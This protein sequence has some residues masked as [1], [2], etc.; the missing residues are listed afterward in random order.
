M[1]K[2]LNYIKYFF[3]IFLWTVFCSYWFAADWNLSWINII[4]RQ[5]WWA[6]ETIRFIPWNPTSSWIQASKEAYL[7]ELKEADFNAYLDQRRTEY[8]TE[9]A[10]NYLISN[11]PDEATVDSYNQY[12]S[13]NR[14]KWTESVKNKKTKLIVHHTAENSSWILTTWDAIKKIQ[15]I[16]KYHTLNRWWWDIWYNFLID[17]LWNIYE[18]RAGGEWVIWAHAKR[19]NS[20]SVWISVLWNF[21]EQKVSTWILNSLTKLLTSL[22]KK[23]N[24]NPNSKVMYHEDKII[25]K[26]DPDPF[27]YIQDAEWY[28]IWWHK[29]WWNTACPWDNLYKLLP[30]IRQQVAK[31]INTYTLTNLDKLVS[32]WSS[33][34]QISDKLIS[35]FTSKWEIKSELTYTWA[36]QLRDQMQKSIQKMKEKYAIKL[37]KGSPT[38]KINYKIW[39]DEARKLLDW[40]ISVLLYELT[41]NFT[42]YQIWCLWTC[43]FD[44]DWNVYLSPLWN[45]SIV[46][47][48]L[49]L[50]IWSNIYTWSSLKITSSKDLVMFKNYKRKSYYSKPRNAFRGI[51][52]IKKQDV[53]TIK[54]KQSNKFAVINTL[55][56]NDYMKW[57]V[58]TNDWESV[59]KNKVMSMISKSY[60]LFYLKNHHPNIPLW[61]D[62]TAVDSPDIFQKYVWA[63]AEITL[64]KRPKAIVAT[65][66]LLIT[67]DW[68]VPILPYFNCSP[69]FTYSAKEKRW[70][71]DT[72]YLI[73][74]IDAAK[75]S[76]FAWHWV[77]MSGKWAEYR[78]KKWWTY[79]QIL[80]YYYPWINIETIQR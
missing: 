69:W 24:I 8:Q 23:Y 43:H 6:N 76:D 52:S 32:K 63:W 28:A 38:T 3:P 64:Q 53:K 78:A 33:G 19:N 18:W 56:F 14:L 47:N 67:F 68:Y 46:D 57:I 27:P 74:N 66:N 58:E 55:A 77:G 37:F 30:Q 5:Q 34:M 21:N 22:A 4:T 16:Y 40:N 15:D 49:V 54:W 17:P 70:W 73:S 65:K 1:K 50:L 13:G 41:F 62:Y 31:W 48:Q 51:I 44:L 2:K 39:L 29:D 75:C 45:I 71:T 9:V 80:Q 20:S 7:N 72:P 25:S 26:K 59:E 61:S 79:Q 60:A 35:Y 12:F 42:A 11:Y 36:I 10:N